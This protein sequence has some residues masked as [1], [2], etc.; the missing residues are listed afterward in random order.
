MSWNTKVLALV[1]YS[2][3]CKMQKQLKSKTFHVEQ[4]N[5]IK[6][7]YGERRMREPRK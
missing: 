6:K 1:L 7:T 3:E 4:R 2:A 5:G